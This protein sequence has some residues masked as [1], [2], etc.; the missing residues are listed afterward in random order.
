MNVEACSLKGLYLIKP[1][2]FS[3]QRGLFF[4]GY[5]QEKYCGLTKNKTFVQDNV[6]LSKKNTLVFLKLKY[7]T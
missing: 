4:E 3:D 7:L 5:H 2:V 6:S 1:Q